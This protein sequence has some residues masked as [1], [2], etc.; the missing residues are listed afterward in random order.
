MTVVSVQ[1]QASGSTR[2][3]RRVSRLRRL[4]LLL[5]CA[6]VVYLVLPASAR[7]LRPEACTGWTERVVDVGY[8]SAA[9]LVVLRRKTRLVKVPSYMAAWPHDGL[10]LPGLVAISDRRS[11]SGRDMLLWH[12]MIHQHQYRR[13]GASRFMLAYV[14]DWHRGLLAGCTFE[15]SYDAIGYEL[16]TDQVI[17]RI[18]SDLGG[19]YSD[20][21]YRFSQMLR[22]PAETVRPTRVYG[23][24]EFD[25]LLRPPIV[26]AQ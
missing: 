2:R 12:E 10:A 1:L 26:S 11:L 20:R 17:T 16:E 22:E 15:E 6:L 7:V 3:T 19:V 14:V 13:D 4:V 8:V 9:E 24:S 21:F 25:Q 23:V 18:R 5:G